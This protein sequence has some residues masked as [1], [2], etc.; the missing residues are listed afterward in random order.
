MQILATMPRPPVGGTPHTVIHAQDKL[1]VRYYAPQGAAA[2]GT[3]RATPVILVPSLINRAWILDLEP[4]R[5]LVDALSKMGHP[6]YLVDWGEPGPEDAEEDV[7]YVLLE[8]LHRSIDRVCRHAQSADAFLL[9]YCLGGTLSAMY[10]A[11]RPARV[12]G[13]VAL[14]APV[15]FS[16]GGRFREFVAPGVFDVERA[17][18]A[19]GLVPVDVMKPAFQ[20][21]DP[22]GNFTKY[23]AIEAAASNPQQLTRVLARER[24][25]E[26]NV[27]MAGAFARE[28]IRKAY[29]EDRLLAGTWT[30]RGE[31]VDLAA[32]KA[33]VHVVVCRRDFI[34]PM[35]AA[36][37]LAAATGGESTTTVL[38]TGH[39]GVVVGS[40][41]PRTFYPLLDSWF[42]EVRP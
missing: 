41:G 11:L 10:A 26:E 30:I 38:D 6:T 36:L 40:E 3:A 22:M 34:T 37:P 1:A 21:L 18:A 7:G 2:G 27:P 16:N 35:A 23:L 29:Q 9:G 39:I 8:L 17:V 15:S 32:I 14:A 12:A 33:P 19:D 28:F 31:R 5:S 24:W 20:M 25:V 13:F 4:G 42:R